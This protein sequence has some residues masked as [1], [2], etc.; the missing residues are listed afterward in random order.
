MSANF[1]GREKEYQNVAGFGES[2]LSLRETFSP[3]STYAERIGKL[4]ADIAAM[5]FGAVDLWDAHC[6]PLWANE[7]HFRGLRAASEQHGV[8]IASMAG[9]MGDDLTAFK[10]LCHVAREIGAPVL[11]VS[12]SLIPKYGEEVAALLERYEIKLGFENHPD[13]KTPSDV[14]EKIG[15]GQRPRIGATLDTG[16]FATHGYPVLNAIDELRDHLFLVHLK[17]IEAPGGHDA[18]PWDRGC[19]DLER[20]VRKLKQ[21]GYNGYMSVEYE[22]L[23]HDPSESCTQ[24]RVKVEEWL[25]APAPAVASESLMF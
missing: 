6:S 24:F 18:A 10:K 15:G 1:L 17:N 16:W 23:D 19:L 7:Q 8:K 3:A 2:A 4:F 21:V 12:G 22:P 13:E 11:G 9:G 20:I 25:A 5:G 14:I